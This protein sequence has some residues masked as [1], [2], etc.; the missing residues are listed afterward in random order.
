[1]DVRFLDSLVTVFERGSIAEAAR[2]LNL[3]AAGVA[4]RIRALEAEIGVSLVAR[5]GRTVRPTAAA[6]AILDRARNIQREVRDLKSV[7]AGGTL[8]GELI[9]GVMP[10]ALSGL[11]PNILGQFAKTHPQIEVRIIRNTSAEIYRQVLDGQV[12]AAITSYPPFAVPKTCEWVQLREEP[13]VVITPAA[14]RARH[15]HAILADEPFIRLDRK[16]YAGQRID[17]YLRKIGIRPNERFELDGLEAIVIMVDRGLGVTLLPDWAPP[18]PEGLSLRKLPLPT[19][20]F[21]RRVGVVWTRA[22]LRA[23]I[24]RA[25]AQEAMRTQRHRHPPNG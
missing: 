6:V 24:I 11:I 16:V 18:W 19:R 22:S 3:T 12:D 20:S 23:G 13:F 21:T 7:A 25:F 4:Q 15:P 5:S 14:M 17:R 1:M 2:Y 9:L 10:T 8:T